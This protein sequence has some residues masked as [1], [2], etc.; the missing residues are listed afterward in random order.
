MEDNL[1]LPLFESIADSPLSDLGVDLA[2]V[3]LDSVFDD[4]LFKDIPIIGGVVSLIKVGSG[5]R[6]RLYLKKILVFLNAMSDISSEDQK[7]FSSFFTTQK[8]RERFGESILLLLDKMTDMNKP[9]LLGLLWAAC[10]K[11]E[12]SYEDTMRISFMI[13]SAY[14]ADLAFLSTMVTGVQRENTPLAES[15]HRAGLVSLAGMDGGTSG[16][17]LSSGMRYTVN[18]F[19][20]ALVSFGLNKMS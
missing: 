17:H 6:D 20:Q 19:G 9:Q 7:H 18:R 15:L 3:A 1:S 11:K 12:L 13:D 5:I 10:S 14:W 8:E 4:G 2:E 16:D